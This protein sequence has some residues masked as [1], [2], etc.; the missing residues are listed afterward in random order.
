MPSALLV[1]QPKHAH[2]PEIPTDSNVIFES[3]VFVFAL[4]CLCLQYVNV[5]KT[6]W[7]LPHSHSGYALNFYLIDPYVALLLVLVMSRRLFW[8][9]VKEVYGA[10]TSHT[11]FYWLVQLFKV[12]LLVTLVMVFLGAAYNVVLRHSLLYILFFCYPL[13]MYFVLFG[14]RIQP[15]FAKTITTASTTATS[16]TADKGTP[17]HKQSRD[18]V[19]MT[20][21]T[22]DVQPQHNCCM[23]PELIR[24][25]AELLKTDFNC[26]IKQ[27]LFNSMLCAYYMGLVPLCFAQNVV[28]YDT[29]WVGQH[30]CLMWVSA[31][32]MFMV[33]FLP[34]KYI[35]VLHRSSLHLG[36][37][38]KVEGRHAHVPYNAWSELQVWQSGSLV[39]HVRGLFKAEGFNNSA[40]PGNSMHSR[41][42]FMFHQPLRVTNWLL[43]ITWA[44]IIYEFLLLLQATDWSH[45]LSLGFLL[46]YNYYELFKLMRD[47]RI[48][49]L[50]YKDEQRVSRGWPTT[51]DSRDDETTRPGKG[52]SHN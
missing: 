42:Y 16:I 46:F 33:H 24:D 45:V 38:C 14:L 17:K 11:C 32:V 3:M 25:E 52:E 29:W 4:I 20:T 8:C 19:A 40:E 31:F 50:A 43:V 1:I 23:C 27:V 44:L 28:Y 10:H 30:V 12:V 9:I 18:A 36:K 7:W 37:W 2:I 51:K 47:R 35:D 41:F 48:L 49:S 26:R 6:V 5:Y 39:K 34:A 13:I 15:L 22:K 21:T